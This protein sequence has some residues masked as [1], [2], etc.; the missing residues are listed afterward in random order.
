MPF[1]FD[2]KGVE[3]LFHVLQM[4]KAPEKQFVVKAAAHP[5]AETGNI[6]RHPPGWPQGALDEGGGGG[7]HA[8]GHS[9]V[10][11]DDA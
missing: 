2:C 7:G 10:S 4:M 11:P 1:M 9:D 8:A 5:G 6:H 3:E